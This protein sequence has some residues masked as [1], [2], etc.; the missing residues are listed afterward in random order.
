[1]FNILACSYILLTTVIILDKLYCYRLGD[2]GMCYHEDQLEG[3]VRVTRCLLH[4]K[5]QHYMQE[6][7]EVLK[8]K[9]PVI[10]SNIASPLGIVQHICRQVS[11]CAQILIQNS[12]NIIN[13]LS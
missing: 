7:Y 6:G 1:M 4:S 12:S 2:C 11:F 8:G 5:Y 9:P 13:L 3:I 10:Y